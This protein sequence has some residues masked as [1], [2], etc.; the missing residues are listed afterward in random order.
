V[1]QFAR[2]GLVATAVMLLAA[3]VPAVTSAYDGSGH[4]L[5]V[6]PSQCVRSYH[7]NCVGAQKGCKHLAKARYLGHFCLGRRR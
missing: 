5:S 6:K 1:I 3:F 2:L 7:G 4:A